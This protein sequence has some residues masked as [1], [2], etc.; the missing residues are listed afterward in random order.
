MTYE[1]WSGDVRLGR[2]SLDFPQCSP[3][4]FSGEFA[5]EPTQEAAVADMAI[6]IDCVALWMQRQT[7]NSAGD[8][9]VRPEF[10]QSRLFTTIGETL[11]RRFNPLLQL[12]RADG[13]VIP[14][15]HLAI[16]D[17]EQP[18]LYPDL[19]AEA[20]GAVA[21]SQCEPDT[22]FGDSPEARE[23][24][25][26]LQAEWEEEERANAWRGDTMLDDV[27]EEAWK[28]EL[29]TIAQ[30]PRDRFL[31]HVVIEHAGDIPADTTWME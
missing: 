27:D 28:A 11:V 6:N 5:A 30:R 1:L 31:L 12:R 26:A 4:V 23:L 13:T 21:D 16:R 20:I 24:F 15:R 19:I 7:R 2:T 8:H 18:T 10:R 22:S 14:T 9:I 29:E 3:V 17:M 25:D